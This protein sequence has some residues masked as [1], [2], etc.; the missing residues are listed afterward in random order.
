V[1]PKSGSWLEA[2]M[3]QVLGNTFWRSGL[4]LLVRWSGGFHQCGSFAAA[5]LS[6]ANQAN[7]T[8]L[9]NQSTSRLG[10]DRN[11]AL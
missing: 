5:C 2:K 11:W 3:K 10:D 4:R 6:L 1:L 7:H 9:T 8:L